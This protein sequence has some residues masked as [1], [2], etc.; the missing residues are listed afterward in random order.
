MDFI[1]GKGRAI[2]GAKKRGSVKI[3]GMDVPVYVAKDIVDAGVNGRILGIARY[4]EKDVFV[5]GELGAEMRKLVL[6]H[7]IFHQIDDVNSCDLTEA[8]V[9][10]MSRGVYEFLV[11]N[12]KWTDLVK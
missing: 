11:N 3:S 7:E 2:K 1:E 5:R 9:D 6:F 12:P 8:Q 4:D 10:R